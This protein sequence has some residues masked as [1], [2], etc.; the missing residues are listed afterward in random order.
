MYHRL[1]TLEKQISSL[2]G[3][4]LEIRVNPTSN[5]FNELRSCISFSTDMRFTD[6]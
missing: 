2:D 1:M 6:I 4:S 5:I 3:A